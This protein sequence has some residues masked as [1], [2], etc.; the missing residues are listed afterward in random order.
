[1]L[2]H[3]VASLIISQVLRSNDAVSQKSRIKSINVP[4]NYRQ[5][6]RALLMFYCF[7]EPHCTVIFLCKSTFCVQ[8]LSQRKVEESGGGRFPWRGIPGEFPHLVLTSVYLQDPPEVL[9]TT[10]LLLQREFFSLANLPTNFRV[11]IKEFL[12]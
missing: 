3:I 6:K 8:M 2:C 9:T 1:M 10:K 11:K 5:A 4:S 7:A 12:Q